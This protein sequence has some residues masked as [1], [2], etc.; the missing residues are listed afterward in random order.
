MARFRHRNRSRVGDAPG[1]HSL[2]S[3]PD[4]AISLNTARLPLG[5][6][7]STPHAS[8]ATVGVPAARLPRWAAA[9]MPYAPPET[10]AQ[11]R[12]ARSMASSVATRLPYGVAAR[13]PTMATE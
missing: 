1:G 2:I 4:A 12:S 10:V 13:L 5:Y 7:T 9:S 6:D 8:T 11:P 3:R